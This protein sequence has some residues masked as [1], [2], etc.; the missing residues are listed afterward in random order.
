MPNHPSAS[1]C[2]RNGPLEIQDIVTSSSV[3][4]PRHGPFEQL[5]RDHQAMVWRYLRFLG[6]DP[7]LADELTQ[8]TFVAVYRHRGSPNSLGAPRPYLR[9]VAAE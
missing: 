8:D 3:P 1:S 2:T 6:C 7:A 9:K 5:V 4:T